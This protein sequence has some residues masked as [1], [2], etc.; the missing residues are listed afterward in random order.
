MHTAKLLSNINLEVVMSKP[1]T[2]V[3]NAN[4]VDPYVIDDI[5]NNGV[6]LDYEAFLAVHGE[7]D[8]ED[9]ESDNPTILLGFQ[10]GGD[11]LW[12]VDKDAEYSLKYNGDHATIQ[13]VHSKY[14]KKDCVYCS[15]CYPNQGDLESNE[16]SLIAY[17]LKEEDISEYAD[18][19][20]KTGITKL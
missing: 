13:V 7:E 6:D 17:S 14:V 20:T 8:A 11:E 16:G 18:P 9:Y 15:P 12:D 19:E 10:K 1:V 3:I 4:A 5:F 2:G